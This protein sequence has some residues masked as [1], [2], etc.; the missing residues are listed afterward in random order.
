MKDIIL[1]AY[2]IAARPKGS[3]SAN[4]A[5]TDRVMASITSNEI[6]SA[7]IRKTSVNKKETLFMKLRHLPKIAIIAIA[8]GALLFVVGTT[9]AVVQTV[10]HLSQVKVNKSGTNE[11][12]RQQ[13][14]VEFDSC[15]AQK[16]EGT[17]YELKRGSNLSAEDGAK[18]LQAQCDMDIITSW[19]QND[20]RSKEK[21]GGDRGLIRFGSTLSLADK[22]KSLEGKKLTLERHEK[23]LSDNVR[24]V[25]NNKEV[26]LESVKPGDTVIYFVPTQYKDMY[27]A[28]NAEEA[29]GAIIFKL[30]LPVR[31]YSLDYRS[32]VHV[33]SACDGNPER[34]CLKS[35]HI[36]QTYLIV[37]NGGGLPSMSDKRTPRNVQGRVVSY[38]A[39]S[40]KLDV[41]K[42]VIYT[43]Q[44][45]RNII[46][47]YN[48]NKVYTLAGFD[49]IYAN[50]SPEDLKIKI[51]DSL[52]IYY[53]EPSSEFATDLSWDE[54]GTIGLMVERTVKDLSVLQKY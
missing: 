26:P 23:T 33:R 3:K 6:F 40:I 47:Q 7:A 16:K 10:S 50:T 54:I 46:E 45:P 38:D 29:D 34:V 5:F 25:E 42:G 14:T 28:N 41:G 22:V 31:Y 52:D 36:N 21:M 18:V 53:L 9:Y 24:V 27:D 15:E 11:F 2:I 43:I 4:T 12:G 8:I 49:N 51:G 17:T 44:T 35:N 20:P 37:T 48:Q 32:Y 1:D 39:N 13:L 30:S 19:I